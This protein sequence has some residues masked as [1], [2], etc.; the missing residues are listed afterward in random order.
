MAQATSDIEQCVKE[1][2]DI[3]NNGAYERL[4]D[5]LDESATVYDPGAP[6][7]VLEG[8]DEFEVHLQELRTGFPD[9]TIE[10]GEMLSEDGVV[11]TEWTA[12][13]THDGQFN[14]I[15]ATNRKIELQG[16]SKTVV[17]DGQI[18]E[19]QVCHDFYAFLE[20]LGL[21]DE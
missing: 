3:W 12:T 18:V 10:I 15:P 6:G 16:M 21:T 20:Q 11:M 14:D 2:I 9:F 7:G 4:P 17:R 8:R 13:A 1:W 5:V 19:D